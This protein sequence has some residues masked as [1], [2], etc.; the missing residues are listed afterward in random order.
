VNDMRQDDLLLATA[1]RAATGATL[2]Y[3]AGQHASARLAAHE[4]GFH[5]GDDP[6][7]ADQLAQGVFEAELTRYME[8]LKI[9]AVVGEERVKD[10][11]PAR[12]GQ[13]IVIVDP[14][15][16]SKPWALLGTGY[17]VAALVLKATDD[18]WVVEAAIIATPLEVFT[19]LAD[20]LL[21]VGPVEGD[22][23]T[24][25][26]MLSVLPE[27]EVLGRSL[28]AV[29]YK[30]ADRPAAQAIVQ[31]LP[32][33]AFITLGGNPMVPQVISRGLTAVVTLKAATNWD[34]VGV[35]MAAATDAVVGDHSGRRLSGATFRQLF[36]QVLLTGN[37]TPIPPLVVA[38]TEDAY[39][40]IVDAIRLAAEGEQ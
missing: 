4:G 22:P 35:L 14:L 2:R 39:R 30:S 33:W 38:K 1:L 19:L 37:V 12:S 3:L 27:N 9:V 32:G 21:L 17:C 15:D 18:R 25:V 24:D 8:A 40:Q 29:A 7:E 11:P 5:H 36:A 20:Q 6:L 16:G 23:A 31:H 13:R 10:V 34:S 28:A 26:A